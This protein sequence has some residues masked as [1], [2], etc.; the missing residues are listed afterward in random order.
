MKRTLLAAVLALLLAGR[1]Q[2]QAPVVNFALTGYASMTTG[3]TGG[4]GGTSVTVS[5]GTALQ[6]AINGNRS[7]LPLTIYINGTITPANSPNLSKIDVKDRNNISIIGV[8]TSGEFNGIGIKIWR[9]R[10]IIIQ[11]VNVHHVLTGD[12]DCITIDGP[13][14]HIWIDHCELHN[15]YQGVDHDYYDGLLDSK[16]NCEYIT[17]SWNYLHDAWKASLCG[18]EDTDNYDRK[19]TYHHNRFENINSR[20][21]LFRFGNGHVFNNYYRDVVS[22]AANS[23]MGACLKIENNYF[24]NARNPYVSAYSAQDGFGDIVGNL[25]VNSP[26]VYSSD[27]HLLTA[28]TAVVPYTYSQVLNNAADVAAVVVPNAGIGHLNTVTAASPAREAQNFR[29]YPNPSHGRTT[30]DFALSQPGSVN[31]SLYN[32]AG[33]KVAEVLSEKMLAAGLHSTTYANQRLPAGMYF[34]VVKTDEASYTRK[35][36]VE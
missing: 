1:A 36:V 29:V 16:N 30:F 13:S 20:L 12:K 15:E 18:Y 24:L 5:T 25:L 33:V 19:I 11:N 17:Y 9:A 23:R 27:T 7:N 22:T 21:P 28:C 14:D 34:C 3:T 31:I 8:G 26:F 6:A 2:A 35:L 32:V 10:N 4:A